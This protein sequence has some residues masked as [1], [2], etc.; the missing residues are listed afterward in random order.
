MEPLPGYYNKT[1][2]PESL[3]DFGVIM[4][5]EKLFLRLFFTTIT[6]AAH[7]FIYT[8]GGVDEFLFTGE[9]GVA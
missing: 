8:T 6:V 7:E 1:T 5:V 2:T 9:E 3:K 4:S